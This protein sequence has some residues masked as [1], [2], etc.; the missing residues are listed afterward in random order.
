MEVYT[1]GCCMTPAG[2]LYQ[3]QGNPKICDFL[4]RMKQQTLGPAN[5]WPWCCW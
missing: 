2:G 1:R 3:N 4:S 5:S